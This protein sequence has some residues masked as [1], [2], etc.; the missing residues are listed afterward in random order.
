MNNQLLVLLHGVCILD[1]VIDFAVGLQK[2]QYS[3][4][5]KVGRVFNQKLVEVGLHYVNCS[6][7]LFNHHTSWLIVIEFSL[8]LL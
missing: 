3:V 1:A 8:V 2:L 7:L 6:F 4:L 5:V